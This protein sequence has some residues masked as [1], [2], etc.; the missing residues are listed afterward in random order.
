MFKELV[1]EEE[2]EL[3]L[4]V[5][6][7]PT[8][9]EKIAKDAKMSVEE[10]TPMLKHMSQKGLLF[11]RITNNGKP[12][13][14][15]PPF[16]PGFYEF[17]MTDPDT[18]KN[19][20][21]GALFRKTIDDLGPLLQNVSVQG[22]GLM[23]VTPI[24][25]EIHAQQKVYSFED[26]LT[27]INNAERY[28]VADC[29]CRTAAKLVGKG[30]EHPIQDV[31]M[32]FDETADYYVRTGRGHYLTK[33]EAI[34]KLE[35]TEK[36][37]LVHCAFQVEGKDYTTFI[38]NCCGCSCSGL[39]QINR[40][41]ANPMSHSNFRAQINED[42]CVACGDCVE[43]CSMNAVTLG[44]NFAGTD[45]EQAPYYKQAKDHWFSKEDIR[46]DFINERKLV[47]NFGTAPCKVACP[48][49]IAV[50]GYIQKASEGK[51]LEAL[52][53][54]KMDNPLPAICGRICPHPCEAACTRNTLDQALS[55]DAIKQFIADKEIER[56]TRY[57]PEKKGHHDNKVAVIGSGPAGLYAAFRLLEDGIKPIIIERGSCTDERKGDIKNLETNGK[58]NAQSNF[59]FGEGGA[60]TFSDGKL[61][62]RSNKRGD[63]GKIY[64]IFVEFGASERILTDAH[65]HIGTDKLPGII[66]GM[67][68]KIIE[69]GG[70]FHFDT[71][72][73]N[74]IIE[75]NIVRG[76][77]IKNLRTNEESEL[78]GDAVILA[79]GHSAV[80]IYKMIAKISP[81]S[82]EAKTFAV[83][84]RV[85]HP[86][87]LIDSIQFHGK[88][89]PQAAEYRLTTQVEGRGVYS[90]CM[91]PGGYIVP[92]ATAENQIVIN[93]MSGS[94]RNS[95]WSDS[96]IVV[97]RRP[98]DI[99]AQFRE[100][101]ESEGCPA[102]AGLYWRT[103]LEEETFRHA[104]GQFAPAQKLTDFLAHKDSS[105][106]PE[107][108]YKPGVVPSRLDEWLPAEISERLQKAFRDFD[109]NMRG[110][111]C[112]DALLIASET[113]TS[114]PVRILRDRETLEC[115]GIARLYPA[116]EGSG[117]SGGIGSSA[118]DGEK[119]AAKIS[120]KLK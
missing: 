88:P 9:I 107:T 14:N 93:G 22:G 73:T 33:E 30:C 15:V 87:S 39:R 55:I 83:G 16:I 63:I 12:F 110:F 28:S 44:T 5:S 11:E 24:M 92:C 35:E 42:K 17:V 68:K 119:I 1:P 6:N 106:L 32:E 116:G 43:V 95:K 54:I 27:F 25:K 80:E 60:G 75:E 13:Y 86:R 76:V 64:R 20:K 112:G 66:S 96:A 102:L 70:E 103:W 101:A 58:L 79:T 18:I 78:L 10:V 36:A 8:S 49:H 99:P 62:T 81:A 120:E 21:V 59:C 105:D 4:H 91:C 2:A 100:K 108:S 26:V 19:P 3:G 104:K 85:E 89:M 82:L 45:A 31:C 38:C 46:D 47:S 113:R 94:G 111:V 115:E 57:I 37:G 48:A 53:Q 67:R 7:K 84:V 97:E 77:K 109:K 118:M 34:A 71:L 69:L 117:Y 41:D 56:E 72:C 90:F 51:Y 40:L 23:K 65:P 52:K 50:Q 74:L 114:T 61:Y 29:A 98:E